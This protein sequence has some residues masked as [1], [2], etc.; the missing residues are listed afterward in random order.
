ML[1]K[2]VLKIRESRDIDRDDETTSK[3]LHRRQECDDIRF[4]FLGY[5][6]RPRRSYDRYGRTFTNFTPAMALGAAKALRQ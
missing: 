6:F 1:R 2:P 5:S 4:D 3:D